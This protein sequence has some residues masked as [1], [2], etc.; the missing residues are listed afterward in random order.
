MYRWRVVVHRGGTKPVRV[1]HA[2]N[3][4]RNRTGAS[5][6]HAMCGHT[7]S[8]LDVANARPDGESRCVACRHLVDPGSI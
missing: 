8:A 6:W 2:F 5:Q 3:R 4:F 7:F 1:V